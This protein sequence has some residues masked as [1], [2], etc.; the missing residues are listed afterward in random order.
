VF[1]YWD[2]TKGEKCVLLVGNRGL[3]C[4][5]KRGDVCTVNGSLVV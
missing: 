2:L 4:V 1:F 3:A 5:L